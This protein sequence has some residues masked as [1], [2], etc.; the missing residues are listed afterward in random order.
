MLT[1]TTAPATVTAVAVNPATGFRG[2]ES[3]RRN[4][5]HHEAGA[6]FVSGLHVYGGCA[7]EASACR[8]PFAP[9]REPAYG[10]L[11]RFAAI[12][13]GSKAKGALPMIFLTRNPSAR[14]AAHRAMAKAALFSD[15]SAAVRLKRYNHH[16]T[17]ARHLEARASEQ[18]VVS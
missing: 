7:W 8:E 16:I 14:A 6:F 11:H 13:G 12:G 17:K 15:S 5:A 9:V 1:T 18:E 3:K 2:P 10:H 4:S